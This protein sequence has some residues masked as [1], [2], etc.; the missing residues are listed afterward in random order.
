MKVVQV[1]IQAMELKDQRN[2]A[3]FAKIIRHQ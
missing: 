1:M 3:I 2:V